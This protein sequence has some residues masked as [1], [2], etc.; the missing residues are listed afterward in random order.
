MKR[1]D[2]LD[3]SGKGE[4][5]DVKLQSTEGDEY[6]AR[7]KAADPVAA[8]L[9]ASRYFQ[10]ETGI[11]THALSATVTDWE[12]LV[13]RYFEERPATLTDKGET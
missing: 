9:K 1:V 2:F 3:L 7:I 12:G 4:C 10:Q 11:V 5:Y 8:S 6:K 13:D